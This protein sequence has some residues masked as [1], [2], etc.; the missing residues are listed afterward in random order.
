MDT[1]MRRPVAIRSPFLAVWTAAALW[2]ALGLWAFAAAVPVALETA[3]FGTHIS[4]VTV[5]TCT[6]VDRGDAAEIR[7]TTT[8][9]RTVLGVPRQ[10]HAGDHITVDI[11]DGQLHARSYGRLGMNL[12]GMVALLFAVL[13]PPAD[14]LGS[15]RTDYRAV[16]EALARTAASMAG[17]ALVGILVVTAMSLFD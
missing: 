7:C 14:L 17:I 3:G 6:T 16:R 13:L 5:T 9:G 11:T 12:V 1:R 4:T 8:D 15:G 10:H 2:T